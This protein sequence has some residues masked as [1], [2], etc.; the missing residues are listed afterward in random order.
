MEV[1]IAMGKDA[2]ECI[3]EHGPAISLEPRLMIMALYSPSGSVVTDEHDNRTSHAISKVTGNYKFCWNDVFPFAPV[4]NKYV[5]QVALHNI[6]LENNEMSW[7]LDDFYQRSQDF[8]DQ[9][10]AAGNTNPVLVVAGRTANLAFSKIYTNPPLSCFG[11]LG[12]CVARFDKF[13]AI[14]GAHH[15]SYHLMSGGDK[16]LCQTF[17]DTWRVANALRQEPWINDANKLLSGLIIETAQRHQT[18]MEA[19]TQLRIPNVN[20]VVAEAYRHLR[21]IDWSMQRENFSM[22]QEQVD[23]ETFLCLVKHS[24]LCAHMTAAYAQVIFKY[25]EL[26]GQDFKTIACDSFFALI[27]NPVGEDLVNKYR[28]L[29]GAADF[30]TIACGSFFALI[31]KPVG[32]AL[33]N[34]YRQL[35]GAADFKTIACDSFFALIGKPGGED[36]VNKYHQLFGAADFKTIAGNSFFAFIRNRPD[37][38]VL[39]NK[40]RQLFGAADFKTIACDGFFALIRNPVGEAC[41]DRYISKYGTDFKKIACGGFFAKLL[42]ADGTSFDVVLHETIARF[43]IDVVSSILPNCISRILDQDYYAALCKALEMGP[44]MPRYCKHHG[45]R[46][47]Q[48]TTNGFDI[49]YATTKTWTTK[50]SMALNKAVPIGSKKVCPTVWNDIHNIHSA[51][52]VMKKR[53][54]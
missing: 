2:Y 15:P 16:H 27:Q 32:E 19:L 29:F 13:I 44:R 8:I 54:I 23:L 24:S 34:K 20:G 40:Y 30:K 52:P 21:F 28:Q 46:L 38:E 17:R 33:V 14:T 53:K 9:E 36:L 12:L 48:L 7:L 25:V 42:T 31:G 41:L 22:I 5:D 37:G 10:H 6:I 43:G 3:F 26:F 4:D 45:A 35:F 18:H 1:P 39:V 49:F 11:V 50:M 47:V 51:G